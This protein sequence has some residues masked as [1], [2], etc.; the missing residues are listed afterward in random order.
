MAIMDIRR[1]RAMFA[2]LAAKGL[3][4]HAYGAAGAKLQTSSLG[5]VIRAVGAVHPTVLGYPPSPAGVRVLVRKA[6]QPLIERILESRRA[7]VYVREAPYGHLVSEKRAA[8]MQ[9]AMEIMKKAV[10]QEPLQTEE[11]RRDQMLADALAD[12]K[13]RGEFL[14]RLGGIVE[15]RW[16][17]HHKVPDQ[18]GMTVI[19]EGRHGTP[20][21]GSEPFSIG[22]EFLQKADALENLAR[23]GYKPVPK[24][25]AQKLAKLRREAAA[26]PDKITYLE[27]MG[28]AGTLAHENKPVA[29]TQKEKRRLLRD[30]ALA[31][32]A[33]HQANYDRF[34]PLKQQM[35]AEA[36]GILRRALSE[37]GEGAEEETIW[38]RRSLAPA[39]HVGAESADIVGTPGSAFFPGVM[40][41]VKRISVEAPLEKPLDWA[42]KATKGLAARWIYSMRPKV[43]KVVKKALYK[44]PI[45]L[46]PRIRLRISK[47]K[48]DEKVRRAMYGKVSQKMTPR[49]TELRKKYR[50]MRYRKLGY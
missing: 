21:T 6:G 7:E 23:G 5:R 22:D 49:M 9:R 25:V 45:A 13:R 17:T 34:L 3:L 32:Q 41:R 16:Q 50:E 18:P 35:H 38:E 36:E 24:E 1:L 26:A 42:T 28:E 4:R 11:I 30:A 43:V 27:K 40:R 48:W 15:T 20:Y 29:Y 46:Y 47:I 8:G 14:R 10:E 37:P 31:R 44:R 19:Q 39:Q 2:Q 33:A 12:P